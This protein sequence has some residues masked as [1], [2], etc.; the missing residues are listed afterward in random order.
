MKHLAVLEMLEGILSRIKEK[1]VVLS[2]DT[3]IVNEIGL[4]SLQT[5]MLLLELEDENCQLRK[6][7]VFLKKPKAFP[8]IYSCGE[9]N[10]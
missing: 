2:L 4:D 10:R 5:I 8:Q 9:A 3:D 7:K 1:K 6:F